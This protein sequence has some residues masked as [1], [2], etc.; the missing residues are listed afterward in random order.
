MCIILIT[1]FI[2]KTNT[3][4]F[5]DGKVP[6]IIFQ[7]LREA[8]IISIQSSNVILISLRMLTIRTY[9]LLCHAKYIL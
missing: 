4:H 7:T 9:F 2:I 6:K 5:S 3:M 8:F 1:N